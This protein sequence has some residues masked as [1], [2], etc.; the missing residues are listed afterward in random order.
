MSYVED[1]SLNIEMPD[2]TYAIEG[3]LDFK[4]CRAIIC[5]IEKQLI[6]SL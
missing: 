4:Q 5:V 1:N 3:E 6:Q 2:F